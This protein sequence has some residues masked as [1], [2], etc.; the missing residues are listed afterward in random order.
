MEGFFVAY[1]MKKILLALLAVPAIVFGQT[2]PSP[3]FSS[4][5]LQN[6]LTAANGGTGTT[7]STGTGSAVLSNSP[8][9][10]TPSLGTP[11]AITLTN[12]AGLPIST[13]VSGLGTGV[14]AGLANAATGSGAPVL[15]TS[16]TISSPT[17]NGTFAGSLTVPSTSL[18]YT[19]SGTGAVSQTLANR[20]A[21]ITYIDSFGAVGNGTTDDSSALYNA[22]NSLGTTGGLVFLDCTKNYAILSNVTIPANVTVRQCRG[23]GPWGNPGIDW[24]SEPLANQPHINLA[25]TATITMSSNTGFDGVILKAGTT[26]PVSSPSGFA[27]TAIKLAAGTAV[28][29]RIKALIVGFATCVDGSAGGD[30]QR[31]EIECD[32]NPAAGVG[33]VIIGNGGD[34]NWFKIRTYPWGTVGAASPTLTRTGIG[35]QILAGPLDDA[36][37][38]LFDYGHAVGL[39]T[40]ANGGVHYTH[41]WMDT[42]STANMYIYNNSGSTFDSINAWTSPLGVVPQTSSNYSIGTLY[43]N[44]NGVASANCVSNVAGANPNIQIAL[45]HVASES[46]YALNLATTGIRLSIGSAILTNING[47]AAPYIVGPAGWTSDQ[48]QIGKI[49]YTDIIAGGALFGGNSQALPSIASASLL[50]PPAGYD[51]FLVTGSTTITNIS[52]NWNNRILILTFNTSCVLSNNSNIILTSGANLSAVGGTTIALWYNQPFGAWYEMWHH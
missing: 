43:C 44:G 40:R 47:G 5:T 50:A 48:V 29:V 9:L 34:S 16:P 52:G 7:T 15:G 17:L 31:W 6:P 27:G 3:T 1:D 26:F 25:S 8:T 36:R 45:L 30:H 39:D 37:M 11:S 28:D 4:L 33:A 24:S 19:A 20:F 42:N 10:V 22:M 51:H 38:D 2:Y 21:Q 23:D 18:T 13:G 14:A 12:G 46:Q 32:G 41:V 35:I 49:L